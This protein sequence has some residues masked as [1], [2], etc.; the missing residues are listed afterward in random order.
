MSE[1]F[2]VFFTF[3]FIAQF[4]ECY[5]GY[6]LQLDVNP[7][8]LLQLFITQTALSKVSYT[9]NTN[10]LAAWFFVS[11]NRLLESFLF[12]Q[13]SMNVKRINEIMFST[14]FTMILSKLF[15]SFLKV[16]FSIFFCVSIQSHENENWQNDIVRPDINFQFNFN[17][18]WIQEPWVISHPPLVS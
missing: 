2:F 7:S 12:S 11:I 9:K 16:N 13:T 6:S 15:D 14:Y 4:V 10:N 1:F 5:C 8:T 17:N 18:N 3:N